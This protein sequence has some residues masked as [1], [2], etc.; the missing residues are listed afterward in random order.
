MG[1]DFYR[2]VLSES[3]RIREEL[4]VVLRHAMQSNLTLVDEEWAELLA[5][6]LHERRIG[7]SY[8]PLPGIRRLRGRRVYEEEWH[9]SYAIL[10]EAGLRVGIVWVAHRKH[11]RDV[12]GA[13]RSFVAMGHRGGLRVN[14]LYAAG[15]GANVE[16]LHL[17]PSDWGVFLWTLY[18][19]WKDEG[20]TLPIDP[21][22]GWDALAAGRR[23]RMACAF[24]GACTRGFTGIR[25][26]GAVF[27]CGRSMDA[28]LA[29]FGTLRE[30]SLETVLASPVR[31]SLL[32]RAT[33]LRT[34]ECSGCP[35]WRLCHGGCPNDAY[36]ET[37]DPL[38][39]TWWCEGRRF[40]F[41][42]AYGRDVAAGALEEPGDAGYLFEVPSAEDPGLPERGQT[43]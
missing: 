37:G 4:G 26:D 7:T 43:P 10:R 24:S 14:P 19:A 39:R 36:L 33:W 35:W 27:S 40:F 6:L 15:L 28:N 41:E 1:K 8:D 17:S 34:T 30:D 25:A 38:R 42:R 20:Q 3:A 16:H 18:Q 9:R 22:R 32:N 2:R 31:R 23:A 5:A 12:E 13:Y 11:L 21:F 29:P